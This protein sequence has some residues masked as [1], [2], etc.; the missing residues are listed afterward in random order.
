MSD[1]GFE[2]KADM[3]DKYYTSA[4]AKMTQN[5][6]KLASLK[7]S[8]KYEKLA[9]KTLESMNFTLEKQQDNTP[10]SARA[11]LML[12]EKIV[13]IKSNKKNA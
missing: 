11:F 2:V 9:I 7:A 8:F 4:L 12:S 1:D 10:A 6:L 5:I 13:T 3:K